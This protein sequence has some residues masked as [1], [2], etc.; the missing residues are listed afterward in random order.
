[1]YKLKLKIIILTARSSAMSCLFQGKF[2]NEDKGYD[3]WVGL[4][5]VDA[6]PAQNNFSKYI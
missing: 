5:P 1:M 4:S 6:Y 3:G 2:P